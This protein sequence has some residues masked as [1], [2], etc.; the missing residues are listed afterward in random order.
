MGLR[1]CP[2]Q[3]AQ[4]ISEPAHAAACLTQYFFIATRT[5]QMP[6]QPAGITKESPALKT[7]STPS[8][9]K[10]ITP[11]RSITYSSSL[12][13]CCQLPGSHSQVPQI[14]PPV[15]LYCTYTLVLG[16]PDTSFGSKPAMEPLVG[17]IA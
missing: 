9:F 4:P 11:S 12:L 3:T 16:S 17:A 6:F 13:S 2:H 7:S 8:D 15:L 5:S 14:K 10:A 1:D